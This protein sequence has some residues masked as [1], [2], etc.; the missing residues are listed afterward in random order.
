MSTDGVAHML[1]VAVV[2]VLAMVMTGLLPN[3]AAILTVGWLGA[4][5]YNE[6]MTGVYRRREHRM[7]GTAQSTKLSE[8]P[9]SQE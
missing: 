6:V 4:R 7:D 2:W 3:M 8:Q 5:L 1:D 9:P